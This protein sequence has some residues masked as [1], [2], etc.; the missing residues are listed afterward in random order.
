MH[1]LIVKLDNPH[2]LKLLTLKVTSQN[3]PFFKS[4]KRGYNYT[5]VVHVLFTVMQVDVISPVVINDTLV[6][7]ETEGKEQHCI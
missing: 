4:T 1:L 7:G 6:E 5:Y 3:T 2:A